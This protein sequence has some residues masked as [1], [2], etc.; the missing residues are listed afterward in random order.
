MTMK[1]HRKP[2]QKMTLKYGGGKRLEWARRHF[3]PRPLAKK[4][5]W[6]K[7]VRLSPF[8]Q[9][10]LTTDKAGV[11]SKKT[12]PPQITKMPLPPPPPPIRPT[13]RRSSSIGSIHESG[14]DSNTESSDGGYVNLESVPKPIAELTQIQEIPQP[15]ENNNS[16]PENMYISAEK[17]RK[18][19]A[20]QKQAAQMKNQM[21]P[22]FKEIMAKQPRTPVSN[23][24]LKPTPSSS[25]HIHGTS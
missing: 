22:V 20:E 6:R 14:S 10:Q 4:L 1:L 25:E 11:G 12:S 24:S 17:V 8:S 3:V 23:K 19:K 2:P 5:G 7:S 13:L 21:S 18:M 16:G 15:M 9:L